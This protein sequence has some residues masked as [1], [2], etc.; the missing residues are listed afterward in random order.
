MR[1]KDNKE[2]V[3]RGSAL[4]ETALVMGLFFL[5]MFGSLNMAFLGYNQMQADGATYIAARAAAA[6]PSS[7][8][9]AAATALAA[10]FPRVSASSVAI[11]TIGSLVQATYVGTSPG[12]VLLGNKGTGN[13]NVYSREVETTQGSTSNIG[14]AIGSQFPYTVGSSGYVVLGNYPSS[15]N[16][17]LAQTLTVNA[18]AKGAVCNNPN[19]VQSNTTCYDAGEFGAHCEA[20]ANL[21]FTN[22]DKTVPATP[23][24]NN[25]REKELTT[26]T[27][28]WNPALSTSNNYKIYSWDASPHTYTAATYNST[29]IVGGGDGTSKC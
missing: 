10:V 14:S 19:G 26:N 7:A 12:L 22:T 3:R 8:P 27:K 2:N 21:K 9:S 1:D 23:S 20:Y 11:T 18:N 17:W 13:F 4:P 5:L 16:I 28:N 15:Y 29:A 24:A 6:N 25:A